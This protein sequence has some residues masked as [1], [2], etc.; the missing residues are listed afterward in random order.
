M[1]HPQIILR[2][3]RGMY[4]LQC[5][6]NVGAVKRG[7]LTLYLDD[8]DSMLD[9]IKTTRRLLGELFE[10]GVVVSD[11]EKTMNFIQSLGSSWNGYV[12]L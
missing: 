5:S 12:G 6:A 9:H 7:Y 4:Q 8:G 11:D 3:L 10:Y 2:H 1:D